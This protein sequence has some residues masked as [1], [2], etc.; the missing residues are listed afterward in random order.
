M[1]EYKNP[2]LILLTANDPS[3]GAACGSGNTAQTPC[4]A[5]G[6][7]SNCTG[8]GNN[9]GWVCNTGTEA[10]NSCDPT[11]NSPFYCA[12]GGVH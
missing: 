11:G 8:V 2:G 10:G 9:A 5:G 4:D 7:T 12:P 1:T 6:S 3:F